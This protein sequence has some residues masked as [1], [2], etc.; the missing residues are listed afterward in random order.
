[1]PK[2]DKELTVELVCSFMN[3]WG[4]SQNCTPLNTDQMILFTKS[5]YEA[6]STLD[7][8]KDE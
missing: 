6:I 2:T 1:M 4:I 8:N 5:V 7:T 3:A